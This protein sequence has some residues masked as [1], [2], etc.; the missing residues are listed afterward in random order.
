MSRKTLKTLLA[1]FT[2]PT[3]LVLLSIG[4]IF[5]NE[6]MV[7]ATARG[8][9]SRMRQ[10]TALGANPNG[11]DFEGHSTPLGMAAYCN[12]PDAVIYLLQHGADLTLSSGSCDTPLQIAE[13]QHN[14][15]IITL[16][17]AHLARRK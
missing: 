9:L 15:V 16:L 7:S 2:I 5:L 13:K 4:S 1:V 8:D 11:K 3:G 17:K 14:T 12:K 10:L 6:E